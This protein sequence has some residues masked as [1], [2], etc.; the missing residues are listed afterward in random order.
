MGFLASTLPRYIINS[1][2]ANII[3]MA[4]GTSVSPH[5]I[6][7][8]RSFRA[9]FVR[10]NLFQSPANLNH[11][12]SSFETGGGTL[13]NEK[14]RGALQKLMVRASC[15]DDVFYKRDIVSSFEK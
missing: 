10:S 5:N 6:T 15:I 8:F 9:I 2:K 1:R 14:S 13:S 4:F 11:L 7:N 12:L 3:G